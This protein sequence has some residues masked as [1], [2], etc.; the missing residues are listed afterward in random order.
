M[1]KYEAVLIFV[2]NMEEEKRNTLLD[3]FKGIIESDG[4]ITN[5]DEWGNRKLAY[6]INDYTDGY[7]VILNFEAKPEVIDEINRVAKISDD[8]MRHMVIKEDK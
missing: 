2:P 1:N 8:V 7:Y 6:E 5:I 3:K 4:T